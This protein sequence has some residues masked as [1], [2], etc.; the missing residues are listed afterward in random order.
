MYQLT[1]IDEQ[2][3]VVVLDSNIP[4]DFALKNTPEFCG[5]FYPKY[6]D[7]TLSKIEPQE[8]TPQE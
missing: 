4:D 5:Q 1:G 3:N 2:G 7:F 6:K 8:N